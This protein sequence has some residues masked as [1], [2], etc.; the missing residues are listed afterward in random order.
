MSLR[1]TSRAFQD[2][3]RIPRICSRRGGNHSPALTWTG[4]PPG[5]RSL[6]LIVDDPDAPSGLFT[7]WVVYGINPAVTGVDEHLPASP[8]LMNGARQGING[9]DEQG[10]SGPQPPRG[11]HHY[12]FHLYALDTDTNMPGGLSRQEV[13]DAMEGHILEEA[14]LTGRYSH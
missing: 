11:T 7:H 9:F 1:L 5:T 4:V 2:G 10:Y 13:D 6:A 8:V 3:G 12:V 14:T